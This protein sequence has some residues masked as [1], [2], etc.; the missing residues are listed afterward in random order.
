MDMD[1]RKFIVMILMTLMC[2]SGLHAQKR[3][4]ALFNGPF[5]QK[6]NAT[7][8]IIKGSDLKEYNLGLFMSLTVTAPSDRDA[9]AEAVSADAPKAVEKEVTYSGGKLAYGFFTFVPLGLDNRYVFY[10]NN[11]SKA[12]VM[13]M[14]GRASTSQ[15][16]KMI[17]K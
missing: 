4:E 10:F 8:I 13:Y 2:A 17:K 7:E 14:Q 1:T 15:V 9:V 11:D 16:K 6:P 12:V 3:V 5:R